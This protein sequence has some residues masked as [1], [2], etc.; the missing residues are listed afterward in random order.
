MSD[1]LRARVLR[2]RDSEAFRQAITADKDPS[3]P[4]RVVL[5]DISHTGALVYLQ[6]AAGNGAVSHAIQRQV[7]KAPIQTLEPEIRPGNGTTAELR[8]E[9][10]RLERERATLHV[11]TIDVES[12]IRYYRYT[13]LISRLDVLLAERGNSTLTDADVSLVFDGATLSISGSPI[14]VWTAVSGHPSAGG[15]FDYSPARQKMKDV[16]PI[17]AGIYW[18][19]PSQLV[20]LSERWLYSWL[21]ETAWGTHRIT[22]HPFDT[23]H[24]FGRGGFFIHGGTTPGSAGCID[25]TTSMA[26][27]AR[28]LAATPPGRKV[29]LTVKYPVTH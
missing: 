26:S 23:T 10:E 8:A 5:G 9:R 3:P 14:D 1:E 4:V 15:A 17:P 28:Q 22:I 18:L 24:T 2:R 6:H 12:E 13:A 19:D 16:G 29:K 25:L 21:Y 11:S 7:T 27:F 20:D